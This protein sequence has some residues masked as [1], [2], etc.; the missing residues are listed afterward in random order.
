[1]KL[2]AGVL[3]G[4]GF[5]R[6]NEQDSLYFLDVSEKMELEVD[7]ENGKGQLDVYEA[8]KTVVRLALKFEGVGQLKAFFTA[9]QSEGLIIYD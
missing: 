4:M 2:L 6:S 3:V 1:M 9:I 7:A 8:D 5:R